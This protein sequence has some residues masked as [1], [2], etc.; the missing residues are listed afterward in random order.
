MSGLSMWLMEHVVRPLNGAGIPIDL[1]GV[2]ATL[3]GA[4]VA[5]VAL[6]FVRASWKRR[7]RMRDAG[8]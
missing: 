3:L 8:M 4:P 7:Q 2:Q 6:A 1:G 5:L